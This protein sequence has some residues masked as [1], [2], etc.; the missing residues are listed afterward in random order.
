MVELNSFKITQQHLEEILTS[1]K[2]IKNLKEVKRTKGVESGFEVHQ[3]AFSKAYFVENVQYGQ[4]NSMEGSVSEMSEEH[5]G[6][7]ED[8]A[9]D[10]RFYHCIAIQKM[11]YVHL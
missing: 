3:N 10:I 6:F 9:L 2:F 4:P 5:L 8:C 1:R 7:L 11:I